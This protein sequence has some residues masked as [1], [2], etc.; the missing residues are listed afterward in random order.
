MISVNALVFRYRLGMVTVSNHNLYQNLAT[1]KLPNCRNLILP[2]FG[3]HATHI[4][5]NSQQT[6]SKQML[7]SRVPP[8]QVIIPNENQSH[9]IAIVRI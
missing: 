2:S 9:L 4:S 5:L 8:K 3:Q 7:F 6:F 1:L